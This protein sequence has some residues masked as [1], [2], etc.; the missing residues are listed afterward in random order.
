MIILNTAMLKD[1]TVSGFNNTT[2]TNGTSSS[3]DEP[4]KIKFKFDKG[5]LNMFIGYIFKDSSLITRMN[6]SNLQKLLEITD[7]REYR[8]DMDAWT[9]LE[10][11]KSALTAKLNKGMTN[12]EVIKVYCIEVLANPIVHNII[13]SIDTLTNLGDSE[14]EFITNAV[15]DRLQFAFI[16]QYKDMLMDIIL[17][18]DTNQFTSYKSI[19]GEM[20]DTCNALMNDIRKS[21]SITSDSTFSLREEIFDV[22]VKEV[23][24][25]ALDPSNVLVT[26][27]KILNEMLSPGYMPGRLYL[28]LG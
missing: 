24:Q 8:A 23:V 1:K 16:V 4:P 28:Y 27:L 22:L 7:E 6:L 12:N 10:F 21:D 25:D 17:R 20:K 13:E 18:M 11:A 26:G 9:R 5:V 14:I 15:N 2:N 3:Y 19:V